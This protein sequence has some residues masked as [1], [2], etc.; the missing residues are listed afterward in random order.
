M[1][2]SVFSKIP[3][4]EWLHN[5]EHFFIVKDKYPV[6]EGHLLI[7]SKKLCPDFFG[8]TTEEKA[9]LPAMITQA[10]SLIE[11]HHS[12]D[13][14]NIGI[15][16]GEAAGQT[17]FHFHCHVIPRYEGDMENPKGGIRNV[18]PGMGDY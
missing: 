15:N 5:N 6:S 4:T 12:P 14:Y 7:V 13:G 18:I 9:E 2:S 16:C 3:V 10:K 1:R 8:L 11:K 17:V